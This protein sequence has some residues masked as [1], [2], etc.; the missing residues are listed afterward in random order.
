VDLQARAVQLDVEHAETDLRHLFR[1]PSGV[2]YLDGNSLGAL[3]AHV[4]QAVRDIVERQWGTD[5]ITSWNVHDWWTAPTRIGDLI[6]RLVGAA[7]GQVAVGDSTTVALYQASSAA[8][9]MRPGRRLVVTDPASFPTDLYVLGGLADQTGHEVVTV[10][11]DG[12]PALLATRGGEVALVALSHVDFRSGRLWDL[13]GLTAATHAAG[14]L[15][16]WDL[17]HSAGAV[18]VGLDRHGV[19]LAVGCGYKYLNGGPGAPAF[20]YVADRHQAAYSPAVRGWHGH[21]EPFAMKPTHRFA[22]GIARVRTGTP[23]LLSMLALEAALD[24]F[25]GVEIDAVRRRSLS[26]TSYLIEALDTLVP[27]VRV[28]SPRDP[29][30]RGSQV[31]AAHPRAY[32]VVQALTARGVIGDFRTPDVIRLGV[33]APYL[34]HADLLRAVRELRVVLDNDEHLALDAGRNA[35]T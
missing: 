12:V 29:A 25:D 9:A 21:A 26:L 35:V 20:T 5:L 14:A 33:A 30:E 34:T 1:L 6:G 16:L 13:P 10:P 19:D 15:V 4:P 32:G 11:P 31:A 3:P 17:S 2:I 8:L 24:V 27:E 18:P 23:P 22:D 7:A 28:V